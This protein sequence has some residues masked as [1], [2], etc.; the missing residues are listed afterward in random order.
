MTTPLH[1]TG[2]ILELSK[3][4][5]IS[6]SILL[7]CTELTTTLKAP[8]Q[9]ILFSVQPVASLVHLQEHLFTLHIASRSKFAP[10]FVDSLLYTRHLTMLRDS[11]YISGHTIACNL[12]VAPS[13]PATPLQPYSSTPSHFTPLTKLLYPSHTPPPTLSQT[14]SSS[15]AYL[16]N[17]HT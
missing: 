6:I 10:Q 13:T 1:K 2:A 11:N 8:L 9:H 12:F 4:Y 3:K 17:C 5:T 15:M 16:F 7:L 14:S